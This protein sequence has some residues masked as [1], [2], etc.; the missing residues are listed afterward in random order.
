MAPVTTQTGNAT[1]QTGKQKRS[2]T[3]KEFVNN[4]FK[5]QERVIKELNAKI[6][7]FIE[8]ERSRR[9]RRESVEAQQQRQIVVSNDVVTSKLI[10]LT[11]AIANIK[12]DLDTHLQLIRS[13]R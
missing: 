3:I 9:H 7:Q 2:T 10:S 13:W 6:D 11:E 8:R 4:E 5:A 12:K 1:T